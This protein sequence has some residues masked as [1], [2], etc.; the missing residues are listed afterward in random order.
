[1]LGKE[2]QAGKKSSNQILCIVPEDVRSFMFF[3]YFILA[4]V[5]EF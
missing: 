5:L 3:T 1:M 2:K 4:A